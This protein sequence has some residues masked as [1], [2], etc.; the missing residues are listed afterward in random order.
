MGSM[1]L[2]VLLALTWPLTTWAEWVKVDSTQTIDV[3]AD[4]SSI[5][6]RNG[7]TRMWELIDYANTQN[8]AGQAFRSSRVLRE[9]DC[10]KREMR[11][12]A[13]T[14]FAGN[15]ALSSVIYSHRTKNPPWQLIEPYS[16][17]ESSW[18]LA[19]ASTQTNKSLHDR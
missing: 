12:V 18:Q 10:K 6:Q 14:I 17:G 7:L 2:L 13:F 5:E 4:L 8:F 16:I 1:R 19:C 15:M 9:F 11:T 3:Y